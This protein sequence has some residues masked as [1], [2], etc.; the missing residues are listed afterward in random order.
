MTVCCRSRA[1][2]MSA[3]PGYRPHVGKLEVVSP[4][5]GQFPALASFP[6]EVSTSR[7]SDPHV[8]VRTTVVLLRALEPARGLTFAASAPSLLLRRTIALARDAL[9]SLDRSPPGRGDRGGTGGDGT[10]RIHH[11]LLGGR[12]RARALGCWSLARA[13]RRACEQQLL[14]TT[15]DLD[16]HDPSPREH[17]ARPRHHV[18]HAARYQGAQ[19]SLRERARRQREVAGERK[20]G[21]PSPPL[22]A[23]DPARGSWVRGHARTVRAQIRLGA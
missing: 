4:P 16:H 10:N 2:S 9:G 5:S 11:R 8:D 23:R 18:A 6:A 1:D 19:G 20:A 17:G 3:L 13:R 12:P 21:E 15:L 14:F 7:S 22:R